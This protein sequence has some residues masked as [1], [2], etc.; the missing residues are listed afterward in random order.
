MYPDYINLFGHSIIKYIDKHN[1]TT[2]ILSFGGPDD[3][4]QHLLNYCLETKKWKN[5]KKIKNIN[6]N[7]NY[8]HISMFSICALF[9]NNNNIIIMSK[10]NNITLIYD[11]P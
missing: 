5:I 2:N 8:Y 7:K 6:F 1:D 3:D 4:N 9:N 11:I 10:D